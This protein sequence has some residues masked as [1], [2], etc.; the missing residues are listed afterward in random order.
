M[1]HLRQRNQNGR[2]EKSFAR[3]IQSNTET[4][5][6]SQFAMGD[7]SRRVAKKNLHPLSE[8]KFTP[9]IEK[10]TVSDTTAF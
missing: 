7:F 8:K 9:E 2:E 1:S 4:K 5:K 3:E 10:A 6:I